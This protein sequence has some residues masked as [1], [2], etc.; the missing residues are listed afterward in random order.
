MPGVQTAAALNANI[1]LKKAEAQRKLVENRDNMIQTQGRK[2]A[3]LTHPPGN[4]I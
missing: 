3:T 4:R 1:N 2:S